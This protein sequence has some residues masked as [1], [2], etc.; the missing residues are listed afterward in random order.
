MSN[1][2]GGYNSNEKGVCKF[3]KSTLDGFGSGGTHFMNF[4]PKPHFSQEFAARQDCA[5]DVFSNPI[6]D[7]VTSHYRNF[8]QNP[9]KLFK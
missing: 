1:A 4:L 6:L 2:F 9:G 8:I 7:P 5:G 3:P